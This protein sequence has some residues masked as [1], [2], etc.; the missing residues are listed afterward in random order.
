MK[1][2]LKTGIAFAFFLAF[3]IQASAQKVDTVTDTELQQFANAYMQIFYTDRDAQSE[4]IAALENHNIS[5]ER[6]NTVS[7]ALQNEDNTLQISPEELESIKEVSVELQLIQNEA[8]QL[9]EKGIEEQGLSVD[10]YIELSDIL[11]ES[12]DLQQKLQEFFPKQ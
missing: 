1:N 12:P 7:Q 6:Y 10:R 3:A 2:L 11:Q 4:M 9:M 8:Q 5:V